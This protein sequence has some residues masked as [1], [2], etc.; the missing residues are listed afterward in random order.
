M[1]SECARVKSRKRRVWGEGR[2]SP[3]SSS[4]QAPPW[5]EAGRP[6]TPG[7]KPWMTGSQGWRLS[8]RHPAHAHFSRSQS[9]PGSVSLGERADCSLQRPQP[10][11]VPLPGPTEPH[12]SSLALWNAASPAI[13]TGGRQES[14]LGVSA[15][16][17]TQRM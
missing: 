12:S 10:E 3:R 13:P 4:S 11:S 17:V 9:R 7:F 14:L 8:H 16:R 1:C 2:L 5:A 15:S 6:Q